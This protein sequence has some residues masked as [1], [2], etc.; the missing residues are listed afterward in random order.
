MD[1]LNDLSS[2]RM[3][4]LEMIES[5]QITPEEGVGLLEGL[6][7]QNEPQ[8]VLAAP[9]ETVDVAPAFVSAQATDSGAEA[10]SPSIPEPGAP[11]EEAAR[12]EVLPKEVPPDLA[13]WRNYWM[14][15]LWI[16]VGIAVF[17]SLLMGS[18]LQSSGFGFWFL[19]A[20]IPFALGVI[21]IVLAV[22]SRRAHWLH[23][24][25]QQAPGERPERIAFSFPIPIGLA[26]WFFRTFK[27]RIPGL[28]S[29]PPNID[30]ILESVNETTSPQ[31]PIYIEV[32][33]GE[34]GEKVQI[35][36]G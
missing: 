12:P 31:N 36:I 9:P 3:K 27:N 23:L 21:I 32:D 19:C 10:A 35:Y 25:V 4:I 13:K 28:D 14:I 16:G 15:P 6:Q 5:G 26:S 7:E 29:V 18:A 34:D 24:R 20:S 8:P 33:E 22:Q 30:Q 17:G 1:D 11:A 2:Q